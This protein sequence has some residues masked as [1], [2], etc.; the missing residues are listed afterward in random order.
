[1]VRKLKIPTL[2]PKNLYV[3][4][5]NYTFSFICDIS[6][7]SSTRPVDALSMLVR[8]SAC[9]KSCNST[10][11]EARSPKNL[12]P[13]IRRQKIL[14]KALSFAILFEVGREYGW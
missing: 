7:L 8:S 14:P 10:A 5:S 9:A 11:A 3:Y 4:I 2:T 1:M 6:I 12:N 13:Y